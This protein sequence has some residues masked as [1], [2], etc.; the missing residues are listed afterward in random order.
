MPTF[1]E[2]FDQARPTLNDDEGDRVTD[3]D[4][5]VYANI[6]LQTAYGFRPDWFIDTLGGLISLPDTG[7][8]IG[9][10]YPL[11][12]STQAALVDYLIARAHA[13][14]DEF[15]EDGKVLAF[16]QNAAAQVKRS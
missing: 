5:L 6:F 11:Q 3:E 12:T 10:T 9:D 14:D 2:I 7:Y 1:K 16:F 15:G 8:F 4:L 13:A